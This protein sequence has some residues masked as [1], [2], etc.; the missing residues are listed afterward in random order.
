M[1]T[2]NESHNPFNQNEIEDFNKSIS[3]IKEAALE[4]AMKNDILKNAK[5]NAKTLVE[6]FVNSIIA[7]SNCRTY[8]N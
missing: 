2:D 4:R 7:D 1:E 3:I 5:K 6:S 8:Y